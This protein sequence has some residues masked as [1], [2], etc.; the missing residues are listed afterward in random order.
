MGCLGGRCLKGGGIAAYNIKM[1]RNRSKKGRVSQIP[2]FIS[3]L[4]E[5]VEVR[6]W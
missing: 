5:M 4:L 6:F 3:K 1:N 2:L